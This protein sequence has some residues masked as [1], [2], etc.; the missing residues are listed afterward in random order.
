M[1]KTVAA[2]PAAGFTAVEPRWRPGRE[3]ADRLV[4]SDPGLNRLLTAVRT[5]VGMA[6]VLGTEWLF[7][8]LTGALQV[9]SHGGQPPPAQVAVQHHEVLVIAML[10]GGVAAMVAGFGVNDPT[11]R[12]QV[13]SLLVMP[14]TVVAALA[15]GLTLG[16]YRP[17]ALA[18]FA[19]L[20]GVGG[21]ARRFGPRGYNSALLMF[22]GDFI[23]FF[24]YG[25]FKIGDLGWL[26]AEVGVAA[27]TLI[28]VRIAL[29]RPDS[30][31]TLQRTQRSYLARGR[32]V[33]ALAL[34]VFDARSRSGARGRVVRLQRQLV[35]LNEAALI[36][37]ALLGDP[38]AS[39]P[40]PS[41]LLL[42]QR[43]FD[44][45]LSLANMARF[46]EAMADMDLP[47][48]VRDSVR[49]ALA[50][51]RAGH[52]A[53][54]RVAA[55]HML[56]QLASEDPAER[57]PGAGVSAQ[58]IRREVVIPHRFA[59]SVIGYCDA[60]EEWLA[61]G[62]AEAAADQR[63]T[64]PEAGG[65]GEGGPG[66]DGGDLFESAVTLNAG[67]LPGSAQVSAH[68]STATGSR[69]GDRMALDPNVRIG[70]QMGVA[71]GAA[72][73]AGDALSPRRFYWAVL[74]AFITF[75]GANHALEQIRKALYRV[76]GTV[77]GIA[78]GS[79]LVSLV[80][81]HTNW[82]VAVILVFVFLGVYLFRVNY[83]FMVIGITVTVA[84]LYVQF[85]EFSNSLLVLR[86]EETT[87][88]AAVAVLT[89][90]LVVPLRTRRV[91]SVALGEELRALRTL[92]ERSSATLLEGATPHQLRQDARAVDSAYQALVTTAQPLR[93]SVLGEVS[94]RLGTTLAAAGAARNYA[95][96][97]VADSH[98]VGRLP[99]GARADVQR[100]GETLGRSV[101]VL[102]RACDDDKS[103]T[104]V[105]SASLFDRAGRAVSVG[106]VPGWVHLVMR[107]FQLLDGALARLAHALDV[108]V[109]NL[110]VL[111]SP[112]GGP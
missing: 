12:A 68:A 101:D 35:R 106:A 107:D 6:A 97:L 83:T 30:A 100:A 49:D 95:R 87:V 38:S 19:V 93:W 8:H 36:I 14:G 4:A 11:T 34:L 73:I 44:L 3:W 39:G 91:I 43:L 48:D 80:G 33:A 16:A 102:V 1:T 77:V 60:M 67:W 78:A 61:L 51:V 29:F 28:A 47:D 81:G 72:V 85:G 63:G 31:R 32:R 57:E 90:L 98:N 103:G 18:S 37:D 65:A 41:A 99:G 112:S 20:L 22:M 46:S 92:A 109:T 40:V 15:V 76:V 104:Y 9:V 96:N 25:P 7:V 88:G 74:A 50:G 27:L 2:V 26:A 52:R 89:V 13:Y 71:V 108:D 105:R 59:L 110:D 10:L 53:G 56:C 84:Q 58:T 23:G 94:Q 55:S 111:E 24:L 17:A 5:V 42:H 66:A 79:G 54:A 82:S 21:W 86:L 70:I 64:R 69:R 75:L 62:Q 45:E